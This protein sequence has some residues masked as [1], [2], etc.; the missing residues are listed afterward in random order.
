MD[1][2]YPIDNYNLDEFTSVAAD[3]GQNDFGFVVTP[4]VDHLIRYHDDPSFRAQYAAA[5][6]V[7][8]DSRFL[9]HVFRITKGVSVKVCPGSDLTARLFDRVIASDDRIVLIGCSDE[10]AHQLA[11]RYRLT[12]LKH[13]NPPMG[14]L[15]DPQAVE[16]CLQFVE[17]NSPFRFC[18]LAVGAPQQE[19]L[20]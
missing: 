5:T 19:T 18:F 14:F 11:T 2:Q 8:L 12:Q 20:A 1:L 16:Q 15:R 4:N 7:L 3:F 13:Y 9:S 6:Y 17:A 10:Q